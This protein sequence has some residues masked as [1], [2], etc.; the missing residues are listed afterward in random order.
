MNVHWNCGAV[1]SNRDCDQQASQKE[2]GPQTLTLQL[3]QRAS[4]R[5]QPPAASR[6]QKL[7]PSTSTQLEPF[8]QSLLTLQGSEQ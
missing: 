5:G 6:R 1:D 7:P 3:M 4:D 8:G 2:A